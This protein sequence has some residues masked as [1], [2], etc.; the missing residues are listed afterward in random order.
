MWS[1]IDIAVIKVESSFDFNDK[2]Y[3]EVCSYIP[4]P[5]D[6]N[7]EKEFPKPGDDVIVLGWGHNKEFR[8]VSK[9]FIY[10]IARV[11]CCLVYFY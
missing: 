2:S 9:S 10:V 7:T 11:I 1:K 8:K 3:E 5:I 4:Q 6:F